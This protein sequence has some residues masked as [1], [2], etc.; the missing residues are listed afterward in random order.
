MFAEGGL[1]MTESYIISL[2]RQA[3]TTTLL[4]S[5]PL[6][7]ISL[8][9]GLLI[10][11]FQ[12]TTQIQDQTLSFVPKIVAVLVATVLCAPWMLKVMVTF[13]QNLLL[14]LQQIAK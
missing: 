8:V 3:L 6:L 10:S 14:S 7:G 4:V 2:G 9:V 1:D 11:I 13:T 12:A 5:A